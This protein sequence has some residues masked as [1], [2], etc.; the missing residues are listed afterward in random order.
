VYDIYDQVKKS[1]KVKKLLLKEFQASL[2]G[3]S[4]WDDAT[5]VYKSQNSSL[6]EK[7]MNGIFKLDIVLRHELS[8]NA[9]KHIPSL[10]EF[11]YQC[12]LNFARVVWKNPMLVYDVGIDKVTIQT[13]KLKLEK[14]AAN[15]IKDTFTYYLP[16]DIDDVVEEH[17]QEETER[18]SEVP[19][20]STEDDPE[21]IEHFDEEQKKEE[22]DEEEH[23]DNDCTQKSDNQSIYSDENEESD[24][25]EQSDDIEANCENDG[26]D[27]TFSEDTSQID[28]KDIN[29]NAFDDE[30]VDDVE[31]NNQDEEPFIHDA[32]V[33]IPRYHQDDMYVGNDHTSDNTSDNTNDNTTELKNIQDTIKKVYIDEKPKNTEIED[34]NNDCDKTVMQQGDIKIVDL[35]KITSRGI[36]D[37]VVSKIQKNNS[38]LAI[39]KKV[40]SQIFV[41]KR[42]HK[43]IGGASF[44]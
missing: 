25:C 10:N 13:N 26:V 1:N 19:V 30:Y 20:L 38:L 22:E 37:G 8:K 11:I 4:A 34:M 32:H 6:L 28:Y 17:E 14:L 44:F 23:T 21:H 27:D 42:E 7:L 15:V 43:R 24:E 29:A 3:I 18:Q 39:K 16:F 41:E 9:E 36:D 35:N 33:P 5:K 12:I 40:K 31:P 2:A